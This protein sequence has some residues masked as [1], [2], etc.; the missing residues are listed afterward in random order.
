M[1]RVVFVLIPVLILLVVS[2]LIWKG[3]EKENPPPAPSSISDSVEKLK[4]DDDPAEE[5]AA[6]PLDES[7]KE[8]IS[9]TEREPVES[10]P[11]LSEARK[12]TLFL[13]DRDNAHP[14]EGAR[15]IVSNPEGYSE[16]EEKKAIEKTTDSSGKASFDTR[17]MCEAL[18]V[19]ISKTGYASLEYEIYA[20]DDCDAE[21]NCYLY[22]RPTVPL[23]GRVVF[24]GSGAPVVG[25]TVEFSQDD[26]LHEEDGFYIV[27]TVTTN[28]QGGFVFAE[29]LPGRPCYLEV[30]LS[31]YSKE[32]ITVDSVEPGIEVEVVLGSGGVIEGFV[33]D[34]AGMTCGEAEVL[35]EKAGEYNWYAPK[36]ET[37][38]GPDGYYRITGLPVPA[39]YRVG[40]LSKDFAEGIS[41]PVELRSPGEARRVDIRVGRKKTS[42][43]LKVLDIENNPMVGVIAYPLSLEGKFSNKDLLLRQIENVA[44][45]DE[46][47]R[48]LFVPIR[49]GSYR[50]VIDF[51][52]WTQ[53][54]EI[55]IAQEGQRVEHTIVLPEMGGLTGIVRNPEGS[56]FPD[57][58]IYFRLPGEGQDGDYPPWEGIDGETIA[59]GWFAGT[60]TDGEGRFQLTNLPK[61]AGFLL[62]DGGDGEFFESTCSRMRLKGVKPGGP[63]MEIVLPPPAMIIGQFA[64]VPS[65]RRLTIGVYREKQH[66]SRAFEISEYGRL[67]LYMS[68]VDETLT[69]SIEPESPKDGAPLFFPDITLS[70]GKT[71][72]LG[73]ITFSPGAS[74]NGCVRDSAGAPLSAS[75]TFRAAD[76]KWRRKTNTY[77]NGYYSFENL[78]VLKGSLS[79]HADRDLWKKIPIDDP[80]LFPKLNITVFRRGFVDGRIKGPEGTDLSRV[81]VCLEAITA[82]GSPDVL[83]GYFSAVRWDGSF[84][85]RLE[86]GSYRLFVRSPDWSNVLQGPIVVVEEGQT[87]ALEFTLPR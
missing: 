77:S 24:D 52:K 20:E 7:A 64:P 49:P 63:P 14:V 72:D 10:S 6:I 70:A 62:L 13:V 54:S 55:V 69:L 29:A 18:R 36:G 58:Y 34:A 30:A 68:E 84:I 1:K 16:S 32:E 3:S 35:I 78:P 41:E 86:P 85:R 12:L 17:G 75:L 19:M 5:P 40:A 28:G 37:K 53:Y 81:E 21:G 59:D 44:K 39:T 51:E 26:T 22:M 66:G 60:R 50:V 76:L 23:R 38:S 11:E 2:V 46:E 57:M 47:G 67:E 9:P 8:A 42:I 65:S 79:V 27:K 80:R 73:T 56:P 43:L 71:W 87:Q 83:S 61:K 4:T 82:D 45:T 15:V 33:R 31:G 74:I 25:A 48:C